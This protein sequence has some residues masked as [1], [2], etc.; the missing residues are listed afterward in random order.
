M[1]S[2]IYRNKVYFIGAIAGASAG[3]LYWRNVGCLTGSCA[4]TS[5]PLR[6]TLYFA[7]MGALLFGFF[8]KEQKDT[9]PAGST[10][11]HA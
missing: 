7:G 1:K 11:Q 8:K 5:N 2:W 3:Y 9:K 10:E 6:S 4:I